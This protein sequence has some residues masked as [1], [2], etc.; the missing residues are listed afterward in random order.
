MLIYVYIKNIVNKQ[1]FKVY[2]YLMCI[3]FIWI[4]LFY[5]DLYNIYITK[6]PK[7]I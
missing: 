6:K 3:Y 2:F 4:I 1:N 5:L 7:V